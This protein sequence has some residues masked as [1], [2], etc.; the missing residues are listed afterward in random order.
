[1][2][3]QFWAIIVKTCRWILTACCTSL[4]YQLQSIFSSWWS[5]ERCSVTEIDWN[6][7]L[8]KI[9]KVHWHLFLNMYFSIPFCVSHWFIRISFLLQFTLSI[10]SNP[11][12]CFHHY[13]CIC[14]YTFDI[15]WIELVSCV[16]GCACIC[17]P[18]LLLGKKASL[19]Y[20]HVTTTSYPIISLICVGSHGNGI[21]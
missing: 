7:V 13:I 19:L 11:H 3:G 9:V 14:S 12:V 10:L 2:L 1:M 8:E 21:A 4:R 20:S 6:S 18:I 15:L 17:Q 5:L 16:E